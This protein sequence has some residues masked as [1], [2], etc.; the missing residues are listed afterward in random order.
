MDDVGGERL[1][2]AADA[3]GQRPRNPI[4]APVGI[5]KDGIW[6]ISPVAGN[7]GLSTTGA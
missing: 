6:T 4:F 2:V 5:E 3:P 1:E 7:A